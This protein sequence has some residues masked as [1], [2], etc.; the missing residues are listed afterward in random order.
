[1]LAKVL[2]GL[3]TY[4]CVCFAWVFFRA[5]NFE[6]ATRMLTAMVGAS[7]NGEAFLST[8]EI[9]QVALVIAA[10]LIAHWRL[11]DTTIETAVTRQPRWLVTGAWALMAGAIILAQGNGDAFIYFQF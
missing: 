9:V 2:L 7:P 6:T 1:V 4:A 3:L 5:A 11:R 10:L 8:R